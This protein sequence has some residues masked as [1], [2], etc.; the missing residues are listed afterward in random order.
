VASTVI[1]NWAQKASRQ[2][3]RS[4]LA[5]GGLAPFS[6]L[7]YANVDLGRSRFA[8]YA[9][10]R[11]ARSAVQQLL[12]GH[13]DERVPNEVTPEAACDEVA[14]DQLYSFL[15]ACGLNELGP[16][17]NQIIDAIRG[18]PE[19]TAR[20]A[21]LSA[22]RQKITRSVFEGSR[23]MD[24]AVL[25]Q[26]IE[27]RIEEAWHPTVDTEYE[28][29][30]ERARAWYQQLQQL[31]PE[32]TAD[33][34]G[35]IGAPATARVLALTIAELTNA[36]VPDLNQEAEGNRRVVGTTR[37]RIHSVFSNFTG[38]ILPDN[39][40]IGRA[41][42]EG[43]Q[44]VHAEAEARLAE[45][46]ARLIVDLA[47]QYLE[48]LRVAV[49]Y[50]ASGLEGDATGRPDKPSMVDEWPIDAPPRALEPAQNELLLEPVGTYP[51]T[52][53]KRVA[54]T[55][56]RPDVQGALLDAV[57]QTV[58]GEDD[59]G[60]QQAINTTR[61]W[62]PSQQVLRTMGTSASAQFTID[63][64]PAALLTRAQRWITRKNTAIGEYVAESLSEYLSGEG[65]DPAEH[66]RR[67]DAFR[68]ALRGGM[69]TARPLVEIDPAANGHFHGD[70]SVTPHV[71]MTPMPFPRNH[72]AR[73]VVAN[74]LHD[75]S[76]SDLEKLFDDG[77]R[78][79]IDITSF[80]D[81]PAQ[82]MVFKSLVGPIADEW[83]QRRMQ[84]NVGGFW[85]WRRARPLRDAV[86]V[87]PGV[88][89]AMIRGWF[90][91]RML[92]HIVMD[93]PRK[94]PVGLLLE[95]GRTAE[96]PSPLL[97]PP[98]VRADDVLPAVLE[99]M[100]IAI[101][102]NPQQAMRPYGRLRDL[103]MGH[104]SPTGSGLPAVLE[105]WLGSGE[106]MRGAPA[107]AAGEAVATGTRTERADALLSFLRSYLEHYQTI[108]ELDFADHD[109]QL[110]RVWE[111]STEVVAELFDLQN[112][113]AKSREDVDF[114][115]GIG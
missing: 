96:F 64:G 97:G 55:V 89:R 78:Q 35:R 93:D 10:E 43:L 52:F 38:Q 16:V 2:V 30:K 24:V 71:V 40:L 68:A 14:Q 86:P 112:L 83:A 80:L 37:Q 12:R 41:V 110:P 99:T 98:V 72:P 69:V 39:P 8:K 15:D 105:R 67:L 22:L 56:G 88:R 84:Q 19:G 13:W 54:Q 46:S 106:T 94:S 45:L 31:I 91:A 58:A 26:R 20:S 81:A 44:S 95:D 73:Q 115:T 102:A 7:G 62:V 104:D 5:P 63:I 50:A 1:G 60:A 51:D 3:D 76:E 18:G 4:G 79:R 29:D 49:S 85:Q 66:Q 107:P 108:Q 28:Q 109:V 33:L 17:H 74:V 82:P 21:Q 34:L 75:R 42:D 48:P 47:N 77:S 11:L 87:A 9:A 57:R 59:A 53:L 36:I 23:E 114:S 103:G 61:H 90:I 111:L 113:V 27:A 70:N 25:M 65:I 92:N 100:G 101:A 6:A 32:R